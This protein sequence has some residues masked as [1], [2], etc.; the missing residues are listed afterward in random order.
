MWSNATYFD[1]HNSRSEAMPTSPH[2]I[3][4]TS[5]EHAL[6]REAWRMFRIMSEFVDGVETMTSVA[7]RGPAVSVFGSARTPQDHWA[8]KSA[9]DV[10]KKLVQNEFAVITGGGPGIMEAGNRGAIEADGTSVGLNIVLPHEQKPNPYQNV[11]LN[12][13]YFFVRKVMF[14]K[15]ACG[16]VCYPGGFGTMD[17]LMESLTLIQTLKIDPFPIVCIGH[18]FWDGL[19]DWIRKTMRDEYKTISPGDLDLFHVTDDID[20]A[21]EIIDHHFDETMYRR[22]I[23]QPIAEPLLE[24]AAGEKRVRQNGIVEG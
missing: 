6:S 24:T 22:Q 1:K 11:S 17:E 3:P 10:S 8:Y 13:R 5:S 15:Y 18:D 21:V 12:F 16:F 4:T 20:E 9:V 2:P 7:E 14:V 23:A 19:V